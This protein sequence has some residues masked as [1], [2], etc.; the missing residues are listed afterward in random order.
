MRET[1]RHT[2]KRVALL[3]LAEN[4]HQI[5]SL[6][7]SGVSKV[8]TVRRRACILRVIAAILMRIRGQTL[9]RDRFAAVRE[10]LPATLLICSI[11]IA[12]IAQRT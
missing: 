5:K 10:A 1:K 6:T 12:P 3:P 8:T 4:L 9:K 11:G 7:D 2:A